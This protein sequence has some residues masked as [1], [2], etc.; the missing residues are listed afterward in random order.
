[1]INTRL[2]NLFQAWKKEIEK[3]VNCLTNIDSSGSFSQLILLIS[4]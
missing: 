1:M 2:N 4:Q 3:K